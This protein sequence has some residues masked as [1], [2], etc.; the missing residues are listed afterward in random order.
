MH[1]G[2]IGASRELRSSLDVTVDGE[3]GTTDFGA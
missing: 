3:I 1:L 2:L